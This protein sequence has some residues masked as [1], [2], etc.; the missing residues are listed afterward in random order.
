MLGSLF[1]VGVVLLAWDLL[2][3]R[4]G[5]PL[6]EA[7][8]VASIQTP[9][10]SLS[11]FGVRSCSATDVGVVSI[12][13]QEP[14]AEVAAYLSAHYGELDERSDGSS[15]TPSLLVIRPRCLRNLKVQA[16]SPNTIEIPEIANN[17]AVSIPQ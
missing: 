15:P 17:P 1:L 11:A 8:I 10:A 6:E 9:S 12:E 13:R 2:H 16:T 7:G 3:L 4:L 14:S 5:E